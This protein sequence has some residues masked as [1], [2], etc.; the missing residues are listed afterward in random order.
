M[1]YLLSAVSILAALCLGLLIAPLMTPRPKPVEGSLVIN[2]RVYQPQELEERLRSTPYHFDNQG[3]L[4]SDLIYR[5]LLLQEAKKQKINSES[6]FLAA[7][8]DFYE[9]SM[10]KTLLDRQNLFNLNISN[11]RQTP[12]TSYPRSAKLAWRVGTHN[13]AISKSAPTKIVSRLT[14]H[15]RIRQ[16]IAKVNASKQ[17]PSRW[18]TL[19]MRCV[20]DFCQLSNANSSFP[21]SA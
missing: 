15:Q 14:C 8:R 9:Q 17:Y 18:P 4:I 10:I 6:E 13:C 3:E 2:Q 21:P 20:S 16:L 5:E 11:A 7:M 19:E 1:K 12:M